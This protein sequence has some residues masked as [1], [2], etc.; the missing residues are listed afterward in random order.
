MSMLFT[1]L[2]LGRIGLSNRVVLSPMCQ[3]SA[4]DG[5]AGDWHLQHL[6]Q[7]G[8][9]GVGL[10][11]LEAT[12]V[13]RR[14]RITHGCLGLYSDACEAALSRIISAARRFAGTTRFGIQLA[15]AGRKA[16]ANRP[17]EEKG[18]PLGRGQD[19][20]QAVAPSALPFSAGWPVPEEL[21]GKG[22]EG[23]LNAFANAALRAARIGFEVVELHAA[24]GYLL[25][26]FLSPIANQRTDSCG[27]SLENRMR[28][29]LAVARAV[30]A[31]LPEDVV[32]GVRIT[33]TDW[34]DGG[35]TPDDAVAF[36]RELRSLGAAYVCVSSGGITHPIQMPAVPGYNVPFAERVKKETGIAVQTVGMIVKPDQA[37]NIIAS[38]QADMVCM[39][40]AFL[41]DP[42]WVWH[43]AEALGADAYY[44]PQYERARRSAWPGAALLRP[45]KTE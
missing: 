35:W 34:V 1:P 26:E 28:F 31:A 17:W 16:S 4:D 32:L 19:P 39:A 15:H 25:H 10:V 9:S 13:E 8:Y 5:V 41:D 14:G 33:G 40:R 6:I 23:I 3:Y 2:R 7:Y 11:T 42:R 45:L 27:G 43:A 12:A 36:A 29:P 37:E 20:W 18:S 22:M 44:P 38:G 30:R 21:D 24:H